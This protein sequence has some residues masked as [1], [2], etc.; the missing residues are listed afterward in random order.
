MASFGDI[1]KYEREARGFSLDE[2]K[3]A[4]RLSE[5]YLTALERSDIAAL[6]GGS[7]N[8]GYIRTYAQFVGADPTPA[9]AA[10]SHAMHMLE[11]RHVD[12]NA[13][14]A[15]KSSRATG[16]D[17]LGGVLVGGLIVLVGISTL[18]VFVWSGA[19]QS[20]SDE[21]S[22]PGAS[23]S[24]ITLRQQRPEPDR[25]PR[26]A[27]EPVASRVH[28]SR[29]LET[30]ERRAGVSGELEITEFGVG[31]GVVDLSLVGKSD[32]FVEGTRVRFW[33][34]VV[35]GTEGDVVRHQWI[36]DGRVVMTTALPLGG[37]HWRTYSGLQLPAGEA[38]VWKVV[39]QDAD[40]HELATLE[41]TCVTQSS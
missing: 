25:F 19:D 11:T 22:S 9:L 16:F 37:P 1:L 13:T 4:T 6:P 12:G 14:N 31:T 26:P 7:F 10:Y 20:V 27:A 33:T 8:T 3:R 41:F 40:G 39:A 30:F 23:V 34:R 17:G 5:R 2:V 21:A 38:G 36:R 29:A 32:R 15:P 24:R 28:S 18:G 35:G